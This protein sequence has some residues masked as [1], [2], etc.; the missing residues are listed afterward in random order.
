MWL[1]NLMHVR[2]RW[3]FQPFWFLFF[4]RLDFFKR[5]SDMVTARMNSETTETPDLSDATE[6][7]KTL[8]QFP[9]YGTMNGNSTGDTCPTCRGTG[10]IPRGYLH[11][12]SVFNCLDCPMFMNLWDHVAPFFIS[13]IG[14]ISQ[15]Q[16]KQSLCRCSVCLAKKF[17]Y[18]HYFT[19]VFLVGRPWRPACCC[20]TM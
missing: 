1:F 18:K 11:E 3:R 12:E 13:N 17:F 2:F 7:V 8:Q 15:Q 9:T 4:F 16:R 20:N 19:C 14:F 5:F 10:R 6:K